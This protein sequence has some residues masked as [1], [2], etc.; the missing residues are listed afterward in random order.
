[1]YSAV[2]PAVRNA[3]IL[4]AVLKEVPMDSFQV[5]LHH[6]LLKSRSSTKQAAIEWFTRV[7]RTGMAA[8]SEFTRR[9][10]CLWVVRPWMRVY[11]KSPPH[12]CSGRGEQVGHTMLGG[13]V[14]LQGGNIRL[15]VRFLAGKAEEALLRFVHRLV[16]TLHLEGDRQRVKWGVLTESSPRTRCDKT[17]AS[18][19]KEA[20]S[21]FRAVY[22]EINL[23]HSWN[24]IFDHQRLQS[25]RIRAN[26]AHIRTVNKINGDRRAYEYEEEPNF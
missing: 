11:F 20:S 16:S 26:L 7:T 4:P 13:E 14:L 15:S 10:D 1:M 19:K 25:A 8:W 21:L 22:V 12:L 2:I 18:C 23:Y 24:K 9:Q 17:L 5:L 3:K 6:L